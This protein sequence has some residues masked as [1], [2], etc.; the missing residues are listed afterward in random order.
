MA[1]QNSRAAILVR[2]RREKVILLDEEG[3]ARDSDG[4]QWGEPLAKADDMGIVRNGH[5]LSVTPQRRRSVSKRV[6]AQ[7]AFKDEIK[8]PP[9]IAVPL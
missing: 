8:K 2:S 1:D 4:R 9:T 6:N 5:R 3:F 7:F